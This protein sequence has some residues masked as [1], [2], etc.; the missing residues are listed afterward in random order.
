MQDI[1]TGGSIAMLPSRGEDEIVPGLFLAEA[2]TALD[3]DFVLANGF[4]FVLNVADDD[5][6]G[7][8]SRRV[9]TGADF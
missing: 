8:T 2:D 6:S 7:D 4:G 3:R 9:P 1:I 5:G